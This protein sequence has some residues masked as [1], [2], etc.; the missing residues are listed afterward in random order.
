MKVIKHI[1]TKTTLSEGDYDIKMV[2]N[3]C[4]RIELQNYLGRNSFVFQDTYNDA[5]LTRWEKVLKLML[6]AV[7]IAKKELKN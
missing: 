1:I 5:T 2:N 6:A 4:G 3:S 7:K